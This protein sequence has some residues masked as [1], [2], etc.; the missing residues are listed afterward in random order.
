MPAQGD[1]FRSSDDRSEK[2]RPERVG[3][4]ND[5]SAQKTMAE[6]LRIER[7]LRRAKEE[8]KR[9]KTTMLGLEH[10]AREARSLGAEKLQR[11]WALQ[12]SGE[13][14][15]EFTREANT[16][17][18]EARKIESR[19]LDASIRYF[20][21]VYEENIL[22]SERAKINGNIVEMSEYIVD[23]SRANTK[24]EQFKTFKVT[25][26]HETLNFKIEI[27]RAKMMRDL[28]TPEEGRYSL[29]GSELQELLDKREKGKQRYHTAWMSERCSQDITHLREIDVHDAQALDHL[30]Q[31]AIAQRKRDRFELIDHTLAAAEEQVTA[32]TKRREL[33]QQEQEY[34]SQEAL[35]S[36]VQHGIPEQARG[37]KIF[38]TTEELIRVLEQRELEARE[39][40]NL[41]LNRLYEAASTSSASAILRDRLRSYQHLWARLR[42]NP[43]GEKDPFSFLEKSPLGLLADVEQAS[44]ER[45]MS[46]TASR[47]GEHLLHALRS[48]KT[49]DATYMKREATRKTW[50]DLAARQGTTNP[51]HEIA[52]SSRVF[53][54]ERAFDT[55]E[56]AWHKAI[57]EDANIRSAIY[58]D[59][60]RSAQGDLK[61]RAE[62]WALEYQARAAEQEL[63]TAEKDSIAG[64]IDL[65]FIDV[66]VQIAHQRL[67]PILAR[68]RGQGVD[69]ENL[70][71]EP[72]DWERI[73]DTIV[74]HWKHEQ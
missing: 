73:R 60:A 4:V 54:A 27:Q 40:Y 62:A 17:A 42:Q 15:L 58:E 43:S 2:R 31:A 67:D 45:E 33:F 16:S 61:A 66:S 18:I 65:S 37:D 10:E 68:L 26:E 72:L 9:N 47:I 53:K 34:L 59:L 57:L 19:Y 49:V 64:T 51:D 32:A 7:A 20:E 23:A 29:E 39:Q 55:A 25:L 8:A 41:L 24:I 12:K 30:K 22:R 38:A 13:V 69:R 46:S 35:I 1:A 21:S 6:L 74:H 3:S 48:G 56:R 28:D 44:D 52:G 11:Y 70:G 63:W 14:S 71:P 36:R 50:R 5:Q